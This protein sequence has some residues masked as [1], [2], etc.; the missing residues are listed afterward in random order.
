[1]FWVIL[2]WFMSLLTILTN[3][4]AGNKSNWTW[5]IA[6]FNQILWLIFA[7]HFEIWGFIP[8]CIFLSSVYVRNL[9]KWRHENDRNRRG[10]RDKRIDN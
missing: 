2:P 10:L 9:L 7:I 1:M 8:T 5:H 3:W 6:L 4:L